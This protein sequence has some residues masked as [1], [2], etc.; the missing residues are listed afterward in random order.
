MTPPEARSMT[1]THQPPAGAARAIDLSLEWQFHVADAAKL[2]LEDKSVD[3]VCGSP[4]Y[5][6]ARTY[7]IGAQR[8]CEA[9]VAWMLDVTTE[10]L[11]VSRGPV[12]WVAAGVTR[13]RNYWPAC[14][15]LMWEWYKR[16]GSMY[17]PVYWHRVGIPGSGHDD[18]FRADIE[19]CMCFKQPGALPWSD[20]T[21]MG[22]PPIWGPGGAMSN[23]LADGK[24]VNPWGGGSTSAGRKINGEKIP[25]SRN[26][27]KTAEELAVMPAIANPGTLLKTINGG[28][29]LGHDLAH[30]SE[31]PYPEGVPEFFIRSLCPPS[32]LVCDPFSGSG[33][34]VATAVKHHRRGIGFDLRQSQVDLGTRRLKDVCG[35]F[36]STTT[37]HLTGAGE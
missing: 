32:G 24:R 4:P 31:A 6:D 8:D 12:I 34:T 27:K 20:N 21:A 26:I 1:P 33:T 11:R 36:S 18:W 9:W 19:Y 25:P 23:R 10:A 13:D 17:R 35:L 29:H 22:H 15:G 37:A 7:G 14:E 28:G 30:E 5:C 16:G 2:P 3:L